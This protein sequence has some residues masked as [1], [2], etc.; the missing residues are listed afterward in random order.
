MAASAIAPVIPAAASRWRTRSGPRLRIPVSVRAIAPATRTSSI[1]AF[2][3]E[4]RDGFVDGVSSNARR[5]SRCRICTS[6]SSRRASILT[7]D[8]YASSAMIKV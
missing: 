5:A 2:L 7:A 1:A 4:P 3:L 6:D 8:W